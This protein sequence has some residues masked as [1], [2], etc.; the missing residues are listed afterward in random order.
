MTPG[1][2]REELT[3]IQER[4]Q[5]LERIVEKQKSANPSYYPICH[6]VTEAWDALERAIELTDELA[7]GVS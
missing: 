4:I 1:E 6:E 3:I 7:M 5:S 2:V